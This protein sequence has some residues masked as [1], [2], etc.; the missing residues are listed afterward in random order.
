MSPGVGSVATP[1]AAAVQPPAAT[2]GP[3]APAKQ[4]K[5]KKSAA[6]KKKTKIVVSP[7]PKRGPAKKKA[8]P[9]KRREVVI[10]EDPEDSEYV[11]DDEDPENLEPEVQFEKESEL[12]LEL[13]RKRIAEL[14]ARKSCKSPEKVPRTRE[15]VLP[16]QSDQVPAVERR[17]NPS[18]GRSLGTFNGKTDLDTFL[19]RFEKCSL[20]FGW[21]KS[22]QVFHLT[23]ALTESAEP[24]V[25]EVGP[26][27]S[28]E[29]V[30][31]LLQTRFGN[32]LRMERFQAELRNR[33]RGRNESLQ[34]LYLDLCRLRANAFDRDSDQ[35]YPDIY[36]MNIF[37]DALNDRDLRREVLMRNPGTMEVAYN[38]ATQLEAIDAYEVPDVEYGRTKHKVRQMDIEEESP[39]VETKQSS[40]ALARRVA[41]LEDALKSSQQ[42][43]S[44]YFP[45]EM[46]RRE[47]VRPTVQYPRSAATGGPSHVQGAANNYRNP[48]A[49]Y[50]KGNYGRTGSAPSQ[51]FSC[52]EYGHYK[53]DCKKPKR[54]YDFSAGRGTEGPRTERDKPGD[55]TQDNAKILYSPVKQRREAYLEVQLGPRKILALLDSGCEQSVIGRN[56]IPKV[57]LEPTNEKLN[58]ADGTDLPLL[59]ETT[60]RFSI[61]GFET[62]CRVVV[63]SAITELILGIEWLQANQCVWDFGSNMFEI[64]GHKGRLRCKR[65]Q[66]S[67]RRILVQEDIEVPGNHTTEVPVLITRPSLN[68]GRG[69]WGVNSK[70]RDPGLLIGSAVYDSKDVRSVCQIIN[71]SD[72]PRT[73]RKGVEL[74]EAEPV[75]IVEE[76]QSATSKNQDVG[77]EEG[78]LDLRQIRTLT[79]EFSSEDSESPRSSESDRIPI[80]KPSESSQDFI[81]EMLDKITAELSSEEKIKVEELLQEN[82]EIFSTSEF[83]LGRTDLVRHTINTGDNQPFKQQLRR[84]PM[85]YLPIIDEHVDKMLANN[86]CEPSISP[87]ASNV[88]L[89]KKSDGSL[90]FC[91]DYRQLNSLTVKDSY[92]LPRIDT[93]LDALG[94]AKFFSTLDLRQGYW[95]VENDPETADKTSFVTRKGSFRF[96]VLPFG[97]SNAPAIFQ[98][99]M[100][101]VM[102]GLTWEAC[103]VFLDDIV[104]MSTT[105][106]QHLERLKAVFGRLKSANL[107]LKPSKCKLFQLRVKFLGSI[108]SAD[109]IEPDPDKIKAITEWPIPTTLTELRAF[110]GLASYYRRHVEG[111]SNIAKPLSDLTR[112]GRPFIWGPDQ[113]AAFETLKDCLV[114]Y[115]VLAPPL[116]EGKYIIDTDASDFAMGAVLQ[117]EQNGIVRVVAY[118]SKT[119]DQ[120]ERQYCTTRKELAAII[121]ALKEFRHYV[122]GGVHFLLRTDHGALTYL[123]KTPVPIGQ[124]ARYLNFLADYNFEIQHRPGTQH[125]NSDGLSRRPCGSTKCTRE[126]CEVGRPT[127]MKSEQCRR[128]R[129]PWNKRVP[130]DRNQQIGPLRSGKNYHRKNQETRRDPQANQR[131]GQPQ[132]PTQGP[133]TNTNDTSLKG[134]DLSWDAIRDAQ[135]ADPLIQKVRELL[136]DP[137]PPVSVD[138]FGLEVVQ[139]WNQRKSLEIINDVLHRNF[140]TAEGLILHKQIV[141]PLPLRTKFLYWV[142]G[143]PTSGHFAIKKTTEKLQSYAYWSGWRKDVELYIRRCDAC[144]K[145]RK[146]PARPQGAMKNGVGLAP[147]QKFHID[148]TGPHRKSSGGHVYL[149]TGICCFTKYLVVVPLRDKSALSVANALLEHVYLVY[150]AAELQIH[151]N[152]PEF[153]NSVLQHLSRMLGIQDLRST[154]YRPVANAAIE[155]VH[156]TINAVFAKTIKENQRDWHEQAKYVAFAYNTAKHNSTTFSPFYL[157]FMREP[158]VGID[159]FLDR[160]EP[161]FQDTDEYSEKVR[162]RMQKA[163]SIV[164]EQLK[165]TFDRAKRRYDQRVKAVH[166]TLN[167]YV[168]FFCPRLKAGRGRKFRKLTDGPFRI[169]RILNEVN[170]VIQ[171][172]PGGRQ[173]VVHVDRLLRYE[174]EPPIVWLRYDENNKHP[175]EDTV[176]KTMSLSTM[177]VK[178]TRVD[179]EVGTRVPIQK[180]ETKIETRKPSV[181][182]DS[183]PKRETVVWRSVPRQFCGRP[184]FTIE[185]KVHGNHAV[186][187]DPGEESRQHGSGQTIKSNI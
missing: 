93:C 146:G 30:I 3:S 92:P 170:Y 39:Q 126:D 118:A 77:L 67:V 120:A 6:S 187:W 100:N 57:P 179:K 53:R 56:L 86:I 80:T 171:K 70:V 8:A 72:L 177:T 104:V 26:S 40:D 10:H 144:C 13:L 117:Q 2:A 103:L 172:V 75:E 87:W 73:L 1:A 116:P 115:P 184:P 165:A 160:S 132:Q 44:S 131:Q 55:R 124:Q 46:P 45:N 151:D 82:K 175:T 123:F 153:V 85:A 140:E 182:K 11:E 88:V 49:S 180:P 157:V 113:Q 68:E 106:E 63:S 69:N 148:L 139:L 181:H 12:E 31:E 47:A 33:K 16:S 51:C 98:R 114:N 143:D 32:R 50:T 90:R 99:L 64:E 83:D 122:M 17:G 134:F 137:N 186:N 78:P 28:L 59:G 97:L 15:A 136:R 147:F 66:R 159:L 22:E 130:R 176:V 174:G 4:T 14:E 52:G 94:G 42:R 158:R 142:H 84:H 169:V 164:Q 7:I 105:F 20:H 135:K 58:T 155:R 149:L 111:F 145:Y 48:S 121:Y 167:S 18:E 156:R 19:V 173:Q 125:G 54:R 21:S 185:K 43:Q 79:E 60:I 61:A 128:F 141:V 133:D 108:V 89:V 35:R 38:I 162:E 168:W 29:T 166:F 41:E 65:A 23:N 127:E 95:Q 107:K 91:I 37:V 62:G 112:K 101:L 183:S 71:L 34:D 81:K 129:N 119:F 154:A 152:G 76:N 5:A 163:Y 24:I 161:A 9:K 36:F 178:N 74:A 150:G 27:G 110:V 138:E 109:G 25:K 96:K 102:R